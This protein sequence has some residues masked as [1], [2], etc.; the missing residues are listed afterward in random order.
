M[1][2]AIRSHSP[3]AIKTLPAAGAISLASPSSSSA[4]RRLSAQATSSPASAWLAPGDSTMRLSPSQRMMVAVPVSTSS[5]R[6]TKS[7]S[8]PASW[9]PATSTS[10]NASRPTAPI[11][12]VR[13]PMRAAATAWLAPLPPALV[14]KPLPPT[15]SPARGIRSHATER[16]MFML[17]NSATMPRSTMET[18]SSAGLTPTVGRRSCALAPL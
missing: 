1:A 6:A 4:T 5:R 13:A 12:H 11:M 16:S 9:S 10:P 18:S 3:W 15:V 7:Q 8:T 2:V 14:I 17:P